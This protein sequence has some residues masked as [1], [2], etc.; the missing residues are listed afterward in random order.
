MRLIIKEVLMLGLLT[1]YLLASYPLTVGL[2]ETILQ[3]RVA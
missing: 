2:L 3:G 1:V